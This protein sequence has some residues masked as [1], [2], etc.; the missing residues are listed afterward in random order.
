MMEEGMVF[1]TIRLEELPSVQ[2]DPMNCLAPD[3]QPI[4]PCR[5][6]W[7]WRRDMTRTRWND[8]I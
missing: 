8:A 2:G 7:W 6:V 5:E 3:S 1:V 4:M